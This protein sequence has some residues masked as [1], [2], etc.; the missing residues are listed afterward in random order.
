MMI[1]MKGD[2]HG[3]VDGR[4]VLEWMMLLVFKILV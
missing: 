3:Y 4:E 2:D 1:K